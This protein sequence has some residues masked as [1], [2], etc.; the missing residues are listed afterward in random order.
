MIAH[1]TFG[2]ANLDLF[3]EVAESPCEFLRGAARGF[4][5]MLDLNPD[6]EYA[7]NARS[8]L[9]HIVEL[10]PQAGCSGV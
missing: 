10:M 3:N 4:R 5:K 7:N 6:H 1:F 2:R 8:Y 9:A